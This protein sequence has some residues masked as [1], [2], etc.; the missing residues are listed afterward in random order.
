VGRYFSRKHGVDYERLIRLEHC[1]TCEEVLHEL[2]RRFGIMHERFLPTGL[3]TVHANV[4]V[5]LR[6]VPLGARARASA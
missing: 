3:P 6:A 1:N 4:V 2:R 5:V